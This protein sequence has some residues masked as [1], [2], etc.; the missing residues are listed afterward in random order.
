MVLKEYQLVGL[1]WLWLMWRMRA[2]GILA[3]EMGLGKTIQ[4]IALIC[5]IKEAQSAQ[6]GFGGGH[7]DDADDGARDGADDGARR[8]HLVVAPASTL[9]NWLR[10]FGLWAPSLVVAKYHGSQALRTQM[11][12]DLDDSTFDVLILPYTYFE[13][14][15]AA[16]QYDR[17]W[18]RRRRWGLGVFDEAHALKTSGSARY[19]RLSQLTIAHRLLLSG[20]PV[21]NNLHELLTLLSFM[22]PRAFPP[23]LA[24]AFAVLDKAR[25]DR[26]SAQGGARGG[27]RGGGGGGGGG[28]RQAARDPDAVAIAKARRLLAPFVLRRRKSEVVIHLLTSLMTSDGL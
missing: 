18:L 19:H 27:G 13:G 16:S 24:D 8:C 17:R 1:N 5:A 21:Q 11:Q 4:V 12:R 23:R 26:S 9:D 2:G 25:R 14:E 10:E 15:G 20:T 22:L 6:S 7:D 3:D 28:G